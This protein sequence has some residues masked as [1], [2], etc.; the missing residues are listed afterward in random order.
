MDLDYSYWKDD[1]AYIGFLDCYPDWWTEGNTV[2]ELEDMLRSSYEDFADLMTSKNT[3][4]DLLPANL[5]HG[6]LFFDTS[7]CVPTQHPVPQPIFA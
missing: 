2:A 3:K 1:G 6:S 5:L 7:R 4:R